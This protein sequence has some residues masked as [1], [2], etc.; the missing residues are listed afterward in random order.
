MDFSNRCLLTLRFRC[1]CRAPGSLTGCH[2]KLSLL[3]QRSHSTQRM[4][5]NSQRGTLFNHKMNEQQMHFYCIVL[6]TDKQ[7]VNIH[8]R[9]ASLHICVHPNAAYIT[10]SD[11]L[12]DCTAVNHWHTQTL[13][14]YRPRS[15][16]NIFGPLSSSTATRTDHTEIHV[17]NLSVIM[18]ILFFFIV[19]NN[20]HGGSKNRNRM[21]IVKN[22]DEVWSAPFVLK[23]SVIDWKPRLMHNIKSDRQPGTA[24]GF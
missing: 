10:R 15:N 16:E 23:C 18:Y 9:P 6:S 24:I 8:N 1:T 3:Q 12:L 4:I 19:I 7:S 22:S 21:G 13:T 5:A 11:L 20:Q 17:C 2:T 14:S